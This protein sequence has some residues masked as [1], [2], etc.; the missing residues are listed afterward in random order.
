M[1]T[2]SAGMDELERRMSFVGGFPGRTRAAP[3]R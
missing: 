1:P 3:K 2:V